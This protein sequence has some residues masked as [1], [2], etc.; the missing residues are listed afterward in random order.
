MILVTALD[1]TITISS[2]TAYNNGKHD[3]LI[4]KHTRSHTLAH[5]T[6]NHVRAHKVKHVTVPRWLLHVLLTTV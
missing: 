6:I 1:S 4:Y 3:N 2:L 5:A